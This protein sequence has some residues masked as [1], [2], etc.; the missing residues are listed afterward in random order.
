MVHPRLRR[1]PSTGAHR[2]RGTSWALTR[3]TLHAV[4]PDPSDPGPIRGLEREAGFHLE[5]AHTVA[6][7]SASTAL[8]LLLAALDL[9][10]GARVL[11][12]A[13]AP[14]W[15]PSAVQR[16][17]LELALVDVQP[18]TLHV[19]IAELRAAASSSSVA[20]V[21]HL[22]GIPCDMDAVSR[23][24]QAAGLPLV[25]LFG[26]AVGARWRARPVGAL[27]HAGVAALDGGQLS[28]FGG[29]LLASD[30]DALAARLRGAIDGLPA[31]PPLQVAG[32]LGT[33]HLRALL[34]HP[35][36]FGVL[37]WAT[38]DHLVRAPDSSGRTRIHPAQAEAARV[39]LAAMSGHLSTCRERAAQ[40]RWALPEDA[41]RQDVPDGALPSWSTLLVRSRDPVASATEARSAG[42]ELGLGALQDLSA[43]GCPVAA[44]AAAECVA[45]PCHR[46]MRD[47][48]I[49]RVIEAV[50][51]WL[52]PA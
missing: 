13:L 45:L 47:K 9:P 4:A 31:P 10:A 29:A 36:A 24:C 22:C 2:P 17:G 5:A 21:A 49:E 6:L 20:L 51:G 33:G 27:A 44:R 48:D 38:P 50:E 15:V 28:A 39:A 41:W 1:I 46:H 3:G 40:L 30:D 37:G 25:E 8:E 52:L 43:G 42:V 19:D 23:A 34:S 12:P 14:A 35:S 32:R 11:C 7:G 26:M 16:A 18:S